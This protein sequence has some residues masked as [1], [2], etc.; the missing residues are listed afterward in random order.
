MRR[1]HS[2][3]IAILVAVGV[4]SGLD[5]QSPYC[6]YHRGTL[7]AIVEQH[8]STLQPGTAADTQVAYSGDTRPT[9]A[10]L[11]YSGDRRAL[12]GMDSVYLDHLP[13]AFLAQLRSRYHTE[14]AFLDRRE[15]LWLP[16]QDTLFSQLA[17]EARRGDSV[18]VFAR[19]VGA[20]RIRHHTTWMFL[21]TEFTTPASRSA[22][23]DFLKSCPQ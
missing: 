8:A 13:M 18:E 21:V 14:V 11:V 19:W 16:V 20:H 2:F 15:T 9:R 5:A 4:T 6:D 12:I 10:F 1:N 7:R 23:D 3:V 22:M 17:A